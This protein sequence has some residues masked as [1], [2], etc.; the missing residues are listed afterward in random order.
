LGWK[1]KKEGKENKKEKKDKRY[2]VASTV[3]SM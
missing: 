3:E 2:V 1:V